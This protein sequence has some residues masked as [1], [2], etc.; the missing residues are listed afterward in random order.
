[1][2]PKYCLN[3]NNENLQEKPQC[4][5]MRCTANSQPR[6]KVLYAV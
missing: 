4:G 1:M 3:T 2:Y 6:A 5:M